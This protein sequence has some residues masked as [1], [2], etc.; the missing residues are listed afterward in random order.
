MNLSVGR[1]K[2]PFGSVFSGS[3]K[4]N[5]LGSGKN[6]KA[7]RL[8]ITPFFRKSTHNRVTSDDDDVNTVLRYQE[9]LLKPSSYLGSVRFTV[10]ASHGNFQPVS[11]R[12]VEIAETELARRKTKLTIAGAATSSA[13]GNSLVGQVRASL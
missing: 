9:D 4:W 1:G 13:S 5:L 3:K 2:L 8:E 12:P 10:H 7:P 11:A 6:E